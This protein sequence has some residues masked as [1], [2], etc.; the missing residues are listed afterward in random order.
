LRPTTIIN[1]S[2]RTSTVKWNDSRAGNTPSPSH[3]RP[4]PR[5]VLLVRCLPLA[6]M[7]AA[8]VGAFAANP[9]T[10]DIAVKSI[11]SNQAPR[12]VDDVL[13]LS[14]KPQRPARF[15]GARFAHESWKE[16]HRYSLNDN[17][18]F[19]LDYPVPEGVRE[20]RY[21]IVVDGLWMGDPS[22]P[23]RETDPQGTEFSVFTL[24]S[25][26][27]RPIVNPRREANDAL[28]FTFRG[29]P[30]KRV[31][32][33]GDFNNWDPFMDP[34]VETAPGIY[35]ITVR[36]L[37]GRHWYVFFSEGR[38]ILDMYNAETGVDP[39]GYTVSYFSTLS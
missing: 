1:K 19:V 11:A 15:V 30:G 21:R 10:L 2:P 33:A 37:A 3:D 12:L 25:E 36:V 38:R 39:D 22:N 27:S 28:T 4:R 23:N 9:V 8:A 17:G 29:E 31:T 14:Y 13:V 20:I 6:F 16:I 34:L 35:R 18:V 24:D 26:P 7:V 5:R 32:I